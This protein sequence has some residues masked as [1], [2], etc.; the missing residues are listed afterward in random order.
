MEFIVV[1]IVLTSTLT[2]TLAVLH[3]DLTQESYHSDC[4][5]IPSLHSVNRHKSIRY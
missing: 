3:L 2:L 1:G 5:I 4:Q